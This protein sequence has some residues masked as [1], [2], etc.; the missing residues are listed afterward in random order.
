MR[1]HK[2]QAEALDQT[3]LSATRLKGLAIA[4]EVHRKTHPAV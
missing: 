4:S 2:I 3:A 1:K